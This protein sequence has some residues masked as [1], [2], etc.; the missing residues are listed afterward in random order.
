MI[1]VPLGGRLGNLCERRIGS[2]DLGIMAMRKPLRGIKPGVLVRLAPEKAPAFRGVIADISG[3][4]L[5]IDTD[6]SV[7]VIGLPN[8]APFLDGRQRLTIATNWLML[9]SSTGAP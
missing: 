1:R 9:H 3:A 2:G 8:G 6:I 7:C 5:C 4:L